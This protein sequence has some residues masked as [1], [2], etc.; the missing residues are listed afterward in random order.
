MADLYFISVAFYFSSCSLI[1]K[2]D[3]VWMGLWFL[4]FVLSIFQFKLINY[5][6]IY[7]M[8]RI[9]KLFIIIT[10]NMFISV[11]FSK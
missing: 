10:V 5:W 11:K 8:W 2:Y 6:S 1:R 9:R 4:K 3:W 7:Y